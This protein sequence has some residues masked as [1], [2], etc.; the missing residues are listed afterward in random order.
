[1]MPSPSSVTRILAVEDD[2]ALASHLQSHLQGCGFDVTVS[3]DGGEGLRLAQEE[4][5][6][7][8][9]MDI[10]LPGSNGLDV[11]QRLRKQRHVPVI[12]M[13]ALGAEQDRIAGFSRGADDYLPK[14]FS[15][16]ELSVRIEAILRRVAYER[17]GQPPLQG[18]ALRFDEQRSDVCH[19]GKWAG[20]TS[21][22]YRLLE[23]FS[24]HAE[25]VLSKA[26]LY[27]HVLH[28][29]YSQHDRS[30]DM[31]V[32]NV[33]RKLKGIGYSATHLESVWGKGYVLTAR[34]A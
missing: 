14:P 5:F 30:L 34:D 3:H 16:G 8:I 21:T 2:P 29:G 25:E 4:D 19:D 1:M 9:L 13:S 20:L 22:E 32:S 12:L 27:Q 6:D 26:F 15:L 23:T 7:L 17:R 24:R 18:G 11:L 33:R 28:R 10:L 31:H